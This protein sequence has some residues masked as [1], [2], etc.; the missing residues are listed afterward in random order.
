V[1]NIWTRHFLAF[2]LVVACGGMLM[3][4]SQKVQRAEKELVRTQRALAHEKEAIRVLRAEWAYLNRPERLELLAAQYL[5]LV[6]PGANA[7]VSHVPYGGD[8]TASAN[9]SSS[10]VQA[11]DISYVVKSALSYTSSSLPVPAQKP[12]HYYSSS[13]SSDTGG[14]R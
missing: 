4:T 12:S 14:R 13:V 6:P 3:H 5:D 9:P 7:L 8:F 11:R 1:K 10:L 2:L